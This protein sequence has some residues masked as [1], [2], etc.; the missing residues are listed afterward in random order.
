MKTEKSDELLKALYIGDIFQFNSD[1]NIIAD[2]KKLLK[3]VL[4]GNNINYLILKNRFIFM[5]NIFGMEGIVYIS[6]EYFSENEFLFEYFCSMVF[7]FG[8]FKISN[9]MSEKFIE[10]LKLL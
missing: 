6:V 8:G 3:S 2:V 1:V 10:N 5:K 4:N 7:I 9:R